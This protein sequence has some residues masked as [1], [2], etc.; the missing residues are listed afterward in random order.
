ML[1]MSIAAE[2][3]A[4]R[5]SRDS[6]DRYLK[7]DCVGADH[8]GG[9]GDGT[10][11]VVDLV[12]CGATRVAASE[13]AVMQH[14]SKSTVRYGPRSS[15]PSRQPSGTTQKLRDDIGLCQQRVSASVTGSSVLT[16]FSRQIPCRI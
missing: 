8:V 11:T 13:Y 1:S 10:R 15:I 7:I 9:R 14:M 4:S 16:S 12:C 3:S 2:T 5:S 6:V